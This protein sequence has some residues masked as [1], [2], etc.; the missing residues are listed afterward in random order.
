MWVTETSTAAGA[1]CARAAHGPRAQPLLPRLL[2][3]RAVQQRERE[4]LHQCAAGGAERRSRV[5]IPRGCA[6]LRDADRVPRTLL[7]TVG[8]DAA[9]CALL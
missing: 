1:A 3:V 7:C 5:R 8:P 6:L 4:Q 9:T 2:L